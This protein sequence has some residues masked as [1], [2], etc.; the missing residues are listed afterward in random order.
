MFDSS[1]AAGRVSGV[2]HFRAGALVF[3][4]SS[5]IAVELPLQ[6][7]EISEGGAGQRMYFFKHPSQPDATIYSTDRGVLKAPQLAATL[8][9]SEQVGKA[10]RRR[11]GRRA[12]LV[13]SLLLIAGCLAGAWLLRIAAVN[14]AVRNI[15]PEWETALGRAAVQ[16]VQGQVIDDPQADLLLEEMLRPLLAAAGDTGPPTYEFHIVD[17]DAINA[18]AAPGGIIIVNRG[19]LQAAERPEQVL[20][21]VAHEMAHVTMRHGVRAMVDSMSWRLLL[22]LATGGTDMPVEWIDAGSKLVQL[23]HSRKQE[24]EAD[25]VGWEHLVR[26][27]IDPRGL[28]EFFE[29]ADSQHPHDSWEL[30]QTHPAPQSRIDGLNKRWEK[31]SDKGRFKPIDPE[32]LRK[33]K[34]ELGLR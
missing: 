25:E 16:S 19:L 10:R 3:E 29:V 11:L 14:F 8:E 15:P 17:D 31:L 27:G 4:T 20:G 28:A 5:G 32:Q 2:I 13:A 33:L 21:V 9:S 1:S 34:E 24:Q 12:L 30:L 6:G 7:L 26:A 18:F 23:R 22:G